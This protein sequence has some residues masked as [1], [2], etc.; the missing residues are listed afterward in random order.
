MNTTFNRKNH[1][2]NLPDSYKKTKDSNNY[3]ILE[4]ER[5]A[6]AK[7]RETLYEIDSILDIN[8]ATGKTLDLYGERVG[9]SRNGATDEK[10]LCMIKAKIMQNL[11]NGSIP[12]IQRALCAIF[13]CDP[14]QVSIT[15]G[16]KPCTV[17]VSNLPLETITKAGFSIEQAE[18]IV[19]SLLPVGVNLET[20]MIEGTFV[21]A[22]NDGLIDA[23]VGFSDVDGGTGGYFG[24][25]D[26]RR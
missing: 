1:A 10:Y 25:L 5:L 24:T 22:E 21:F 19:Q 8:N 26:E 4:V 2:K 3:K 9:Q 18:K 12:S 20:F 23:N 17:V 13:D 11:S 16:D 15:N 6:C 7:L 14:S